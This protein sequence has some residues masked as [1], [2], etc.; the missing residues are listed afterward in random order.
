MKQINLVAML[1]VA[2]ATQ[3]AVAQDSALKLTVLEGQ[4]ASNN[5]QT[6]AATPATVEVRDAQH[7]AVP[8]ARVRFTVPSLGPGGKFADEARTFDTWSDE[9]GR[10][11]MPALIPNQVEGRFSITVLAQMAG[12]E[13]TAV[14]T[15]HNRAFARPAGA[16]MYAAPSAPAV[17]SG[18]GRMLL[19]I[20]GV[21]AAV[22]A[23]SILGVKGNS[24]RSGA[25]ASTTPSTVSVGGIS[26]GGPQ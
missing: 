1:I 16:Q 5:I 24:G 18:R 21:G 11:T 8:G 26:I 22:A 10:A 9:K 13:G 12:S 25:A 20:A 15:Q 23:A 6:R 17:K 7:R 14:V 4:D 3:P 19:V 2:L